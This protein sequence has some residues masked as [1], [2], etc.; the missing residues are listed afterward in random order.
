MDA[1]VQSSVST[2]TSFPTWD[3]NVID[4]IVPIIEGIK[5]TEQSATIA[6]YLQLNTVPQLPLVGIPWTGYLTENI[7]FSV[8][9]NTIKNTLIG[10]GIDTF[11]PDYD[12]INDK[13]VV[14]V[15]PV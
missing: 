7:D 3:W 11:I 2:D 8:V 15:K 12:I 13:L 4:G 1:Q 6:T 14:K 9:D 10:L 5:E